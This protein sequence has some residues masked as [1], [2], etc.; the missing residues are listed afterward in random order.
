MVKRL[1]SLAVL[2][3]S[4]L[5]ASAA[6][7]GDV[8]GN[9]VVDIDDL[10]AVIN[11]MLHKNADP[12]IEARADIDGNGMVDIDDLNVVINVM[13]GKDSGGTAETHTYTVNG[14][15]FKMVDVEGGT[16]TMGATSEQD[17]QNPNDSEL[18][19]HQ[20]TLTGYSI[21]QTEVTVG[22]WKAV[23]GKAPYG[24]VIDSHPV[25]VVSWNDCQVFIAKLNEMT[26]QQFRLPTEAQWEFAARGG[27]KSKGYIYAGSNNIDEVAWYYDNAG[28]GGTSNPDYGEH[29]VATKA[30]NELGLYDMSGNVA[31]LCSD[32]FDAYN[33]G[34]QVNPLGPDTGTYRVYRS[35][36]WAH[37]E[38]YSRVS[39]RE[40]TRMDNTFV[41]VGF[42]LAMGGSTEAPATAMS[43][44]PATVSIAQGLK[45]QLSLEFEP[46]NAN[47]NILWTTANA[48]IATVDASG[49]VTAINPGTTV[50][51]ATSAR[52][53]NISA[54]CTVTVTALSD[55]T[56]TVGGVTFKMIGVQGGTFTMGATSEQGSDAAYDEN[57]AHQVTVSNF[58]IGQTEVTQELWIAVMGYNSSVMTAAWGYTDNIK[59]PVDNVGWEDCLIFIDKLNELTGMNFRL[60]TEAEWEFAARGGVKSKGCKYAGGS[61]IGAVAWY[62][63]NAYFDDTAHPDHGTHAVATKAANELGLYDMCGNLSEWCHDWYGAY[64]SEAQVNPAG[65]GTGSVHVH[66]G[67]SWDSVGQY[68]RVST[69]E[70]YAPYFPCAS[71]GFRIAL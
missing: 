21:G 24:N 28:T 69:R 20:V 59:R 55:A 18:P 13:V 37:Y 15:S 6:V 48:A 64:S 63:D 32:W 2:L 26:G 17:S 8:N 62:R 39:R 67:G 5:A 22:L 68:C 36:S 42:R 53:S 38:W 16:F 25:D 34:A 40:F 50:I 12:D 46:V 45:R 58:S 11:V 9:G 10:N 70:S 51:T 4:M 33:S 41:G 49:L 30:P 65:P 19:T 35:G 29:P 54:S 52:N 1:F 57:P 66:R 60:P 61:N 44:V 14:V 43:V 27:N 71:V 7:R 47:D 56:Y 31:E 3:T 23:M